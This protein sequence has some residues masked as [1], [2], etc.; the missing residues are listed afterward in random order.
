MTVCTLLFGYAN[1]TLILEAAGSLE[2]LITFYMAAQRRNREQRNFHI[3]G[4]VSRL[5]ND[6][7]NRYLI[8]I[9]LCFPC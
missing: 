1:S 8:N 4:N 3:E 5:Q 2:T 9:F 6:R 7:N